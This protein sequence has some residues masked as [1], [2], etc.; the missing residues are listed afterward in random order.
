MM[1]NFDSKTGVS[2]GG[3]IPA[4]VPAD[5]P[6]HRG[7]LNGHA[8]NG[9]VAKGVNGAATANGHGRHSVTDNSGSIPLRPDSGD[10][11]P[12]GG[13]RAGSPGDTARM[14]S[15]MGDPGATP[16]LVPK[17][18]G[19]TPTVQ[20]IESDL[21]E[22][23]K[24][25]TNVDTLVARMV[26]DSGLATSEEV[27]HCLAMAR[28]QEDQNQQSLMHFLVNNRYATERQLSRL[29]QQ[30]EAERSGQKIAGYKFLGKLGAGAMA[31]VHKAKQLSLDRI[32]AIKILPRKFSSNPQFIERFYAEGRAAAALNHPNIVQAYDVGKSGEFHYFVMEFV[33]GRT[34][35]DDIVKHK[36]YPEGEAIDVIIQIAEALQHAHEKGLIHRDVKPKNIMITKEGVAKLADM[37]LARAMNDKEMAEAEAGKAFGTPYYISPEQIRGEVNITAAADIYSLGATLYHM[38][39]GSVPYDGKNPSA[40]MHKHLKAEL[41]PPDHVNP[42]L[43]AGISEVIEM[44]MNKDPKQRYKSCKDLLIDLRAVRKKESPPLA[45]KDVLPQEDIS[46]LVE[47]EHAASAFIAE[48]RSDARRAP[49]PYLVWGLIVSLVF[50]VGV[51]I[52]LLIMR[53]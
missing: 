11:N 32:V 35:F 14:G 41:V 44:M 42:K 21:Q 27:E 39:T 7:S 15:K 49:N 5:N 36:R 26:V 24:G 48:D 46:A 12:L 1:S 9:V 29:K 17:A 22:V 20:A 37:G 40:V 3:P 53:G 30:L 6:V 33:D 23:A 13:S 43:S 45:H 2:A 47:A 38:V 4:I 50:S 52:V 18:P 16:Q 25:G 34:V 10:T 19:P 51:N 31:T 8:G 28:Q